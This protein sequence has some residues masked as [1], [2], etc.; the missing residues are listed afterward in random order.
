MLYFL[1]LNTQE[2]IIFYYPATQFVLLTSAAPGDPILMISIF[3]FSFIFIQMLSNSQ[4]RV[5]K[6]NSEGRGLN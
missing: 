5:F 2:E 1:Q 4:G 3:Y 6:K